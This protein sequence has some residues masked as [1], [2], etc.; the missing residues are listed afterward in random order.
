MGE[1]IIEETPLIVAELDVW[2]DGSEE[3]LTEFDALPPNVRQYYMSK[4][5]FSANQDQLLEFAN[6]SGKSFNSK[7]QALEAGKVLAIFENN[8]FE[9][10]E[11]TSAFSKDAARLNHSCMPNATHGWDDV[12]G[13]YFVKAIQDIAQ[14]EEILDSYIKEIAPKAVR[15]EG[16]SKYGFTCTCPAC[17]TSTYATKTEERRSELYNLEQQISESRFN[18]EF[19]EEGGDEPLPAEEKR[20]I[21]ARMLDI[22][23]DE[24]GMKDSKG[25]W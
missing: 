25:D 18:E 19:H 2:G 1:V 24:P 3:I 10:G 9:V 7:E 11:H 20:R 15:D 4:Y 13:L 14:G 6:S 23:S 17:G 22:M 21:L 16:L 8:A 12:K 5:T